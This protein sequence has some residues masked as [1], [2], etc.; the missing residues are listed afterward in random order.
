MEA[1]NQTRVCL[2]PGRLKMQVTLSTL[3]RGPDS[4]MPG[5][6]LREVWAPAP[7]SPGQL[8]QAWPQPGA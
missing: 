3:A 7:L 1:Q 2:L 5:R 8:T 4:Q 6:G